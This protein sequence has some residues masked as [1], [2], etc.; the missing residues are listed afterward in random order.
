MRLVHDI[1]DLLSAVTTGICEIHGKPSLECGAA[2]E[3][4]T[5]GTTVVGGAAL[6]T[7]LGGRGGTAVGGV[8]G[9]LAGLWLNGTGEEAAA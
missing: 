9:L 8:L 7:M 2:K 1:I 4:A 3:A 6:G 5:L